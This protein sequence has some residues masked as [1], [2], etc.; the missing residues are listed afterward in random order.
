LSRETT[1]E[2]DLHPRTD[3]AALGEIFTDLCERVASD[4][5]LK[6]YV[7]RSVGVKL[8]YDDFRIATRELSLPQPTGDAKA[9]RHAAG[10]CLKRMA[11]D[12][13]L[14]LLGV[15]VG[16]LCRPGTWVAEPGAIAPSK[17]NEATLPL[18]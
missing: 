1:F 11:L 18:F 13:K 5:R 2:R 16:A 10:L 15:R 6:G 9:I 12:R 17:S 3:R 4:L 7:G 8:R 14:R